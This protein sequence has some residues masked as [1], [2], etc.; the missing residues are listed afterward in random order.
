MF[1][2]VAPVPSYL[3]VRPGL[4]DSIVHRDDILCAGNRG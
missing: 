1:D 3:H 2:R 4:S